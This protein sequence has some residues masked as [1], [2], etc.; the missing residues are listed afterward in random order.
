MIA[1][2][3]HCAHGGGAWSGLVQLDP[4]TA[5]VYAL[6]AICLVL[7]GAILTT[8]VQGLGIPERAAVLAAIGT[9]LF[10]IARFKRDAE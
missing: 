6:I 3:L 9:T 8:N 10:I 2:V 4:P 7:V 1:R 5:A